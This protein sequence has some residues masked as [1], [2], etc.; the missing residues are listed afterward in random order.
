MADDEKGGDS[1]GEVVT[2]EQKANARLHAARTWK[3][4]VELDFKESYF[5]AAP[6]RQRQI[7]SMTMPGTARM[8]DAP[9]LNTD[10]AFIICGDFTTAIVNAFMPE[11]EIWCERGPGMDLPK[12]VWDQVKDRVKEGDNKILL[13][14]YCKFGGPL[15]KK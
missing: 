15:T 4:Y 6:N 9:E 1:T 2:L 5:F 7:N 11:A 13:N 12:G 8:L 3:S 14:G 10:Q